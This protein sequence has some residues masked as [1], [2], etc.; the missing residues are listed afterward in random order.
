MVSAGKSIVRTSAGRNVLSR[1]G[2][3]ILEIPALGTTSCFFGGSHET[4][5]DSA[6]ETHYPLL[7]RCVRPGGRNRSW[8]LPLGRDVQ[9]GN[10]AQCR[11]GGSRLSRTGRLGAFGF[12]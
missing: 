8:P 4:V 6:L 11:R 10:V 2:A 12:C 1:H 9:A 7:S 3:A 5:Y